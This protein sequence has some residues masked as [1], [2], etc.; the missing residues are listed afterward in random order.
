MPHPLPAARPPLVSIVVPCY[1]TLPAQLQLLD[2]TLSTVDAQ[3]CDD[4]E[5]VVVDDGSP[6]EP[7]RERMLHSLRAVYDRQWSLVRGWPEAEAA[8]DRGLARLTDPCLD[9]LVENAAH[10]P[11]AGHDAGTRQGARLPAVER[12]QLARVTTGPS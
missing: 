7:T 8:Y 5:V 6:I 9:G 4:Y 11:R 3:G 10:L 12:P 2:E 1:I